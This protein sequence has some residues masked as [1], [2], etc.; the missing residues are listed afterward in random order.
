MTGYVRQDP[1]YQRG[2][3]NGGK[4]S[5]LGR[6]EAPSAPSIRMACQGTMILGSD[7]RGPSWK[8]AIVPLLISD[9]MHTTKVAGKE[10]AQSNSMGDP[11]TSDDSNLSS[12]PYMLEWGS[13]SMRTPTRV[14][15]KCQLHYRTYIDL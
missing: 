1:Q 12:Q 3:G 9:R 14:T 4:D 5:N 2:E 10:M 6:F 15:L 7:P 8:D 11:N 13:K